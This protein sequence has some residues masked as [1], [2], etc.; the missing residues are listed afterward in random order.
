MG[1]FARIMEGLA[2][3][4]TDRSTIMLDATY[5]RAHHTASSLR[6]K[7]GGQTDRQDERRHEHKAARCHRQYR[8]PYSVLHL[9]RSGRS[10]CSSFGPLATSKWS[11]WSEK[12]LLN[13]TTSSGT[14]SIRLIGLWARYPRCSS[15]RKSGA[16][17]P[18]VPS[19]PSLCCLCLF[20]SY[21]R[22][23][24]HTFQVLHQ[25]LLQGSC[26]CL[27]Q[28]G[29][30]RRHQELRP[31]KHQPHTVRRFVLEPELALSGLHMPP[32]AKCHQA[33]K[34]LLSSSCRFL[35]FTC[36]S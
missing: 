18:T 5:L 6:L 19:N 12:T 17:G 15:W 29:C 1:V 16:C 21:K 11:T 20:V 36:L 9:R 28:S 34:L 22:I 4:E 35:T 27:N 32:R 13:C 14:N 3:E 10:T 7:K 26:P 31:P 25:P 2:A 23:G 30:L 8:A 24:L 33:G